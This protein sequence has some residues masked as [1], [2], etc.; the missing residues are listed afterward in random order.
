MNETLKLSINFINN[1][2]N[3]LYFN[4]INTNLY[5]YNS[6]EDTYNIKQ[7]DKLLRFKN[8]NNTKSNFKSL[9]NC[10]VIF[11]NDFNDNLN[12]YYNINNINN[13]FSKIL[14][15]YSSYSMNIPSFSLL[16]KSN[17]IFKYYKNI[18]LKLEAL[19]LGYKYKN[20]S[21]ISDI[22]SYKSNMYNANHSEKIIKSYLVN[23]SNKK[24]ESIMLYDNNKITSIFR[25]YSN[26]YLN[27]KYKLNNSIN[28]NL[29]LF[30]NLKTNIFEYDNYNNY[31]LT[32]QLSLNI[33]KI[34]NQNFKINNMSILSQSVIVKD[35][36]NDDNSLFISE[37]Q[38][39][40]INNN[41]EY[42]NK[43]NKLFKYKGNSKKIVK[44]II[45]KPINNIKNIKK[46]N[47][48]IT[49]TI[50]NKNIN[51]IKNSSKYKNSLKENNCNIN[52]EIKDGYYTQNKNINSKNN[53]A[54]NMCCIKSNTYKNTIKSSNKKIETNLENKKN[55]VCRNNKLN[56]INNNA[57]NTLNSNKSVLNNNIKCSKDSNANFSKTKL[58]SNFNSRNNN[59]P[60]IPTNKRSFFNNTFIRNN[61]NAFKN[62]TT[63][64]KNLNN[65]IK[66]S[67][68][69]NIYCLNFKTNFDN[70]N[71]TKL[72]NQKISNLNNIN[73][74]NNNNNNN[75][76]LNPT[77]YKAKE[78]FKLP[79]K[80]G[81][82]KLINN[83][84]LN[85]N[86]ICS[87]KEKIV[88]KNIHPVKNNSSKSKKITNFNS[89][90]KFTNKKN[91]NN[92]KFINNLNQNT[93][94]KKPTLVKT[95]TS[96]SNFK[97]F[98][99]I[100]S[101]NEPSTLSNSNEKS[102]KKNIKNE[103][104]NINNAFNNA[105]KQIFF[106]V[107]INN[108]KKYNSEFNNE[109]PHKFDN[110][111]T[112]NF[113]K[114]KTLYKK[115]NNC[116]TTSSKSIDITI[117]NKEL[118]NN[119]LNQ[120][121]AKSQNIDCLNLNIKTFLNDYC[122]LKLVRDK[123]NKYT[124]LENELNINKNIYKCLNSC[125]NN[126]N[127]ISNKDCICK[128]SKINKKSI[129]MHTFNYNKSDF[130]FKKSTNRNNIKNNTTK[131]LNII[132]SNIELIAAN[133]TKNFNNNNNNNNTNKEIRI[134]NIHKSCNSCFSLNNEPIPLDKQKKIPYLKKLVPM[135]F[136][137]NNL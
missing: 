66:N 30:N 7:I 75:L 134:E 45:P 111:N 107:K 113:H 54:K 36:I 82:N 29:Y 31:L 110:F 47:I 86:K 112:G 63:P 14:D 120:N 15:Y 71:D 32:K 92:N 65:N 70:E 68:K 2:N 135:S 37:S 64:P 56:T 40:N 133:D 85:N 53:I 125:T 59:N 108:N 114:T 127:N 128:R 12:S 131:D 21:T 25:L 5:Y 9:Y 126:L 102:L 52:K 119:D 48:T 60:N 91:N 87:L 42:S 4:I 116:N 129:S 49:T 27:S 124:G 88:N 105:N 34:N 95:N 117:I 106:R 61:K 28:F 74:D 8:N 137:K 123:S 17:P 115:N 98:N 58:A 99:K 50:N 109:N 23:T 73:N 118:S 43:E 18:K 93:E 67:K 6:D 136:K 130:I 103:I 122:E 20:D 19:E 69:E 62:N 89:Y 26:K 10:N 13:I 83:K 80:E 46:N 96:C 84:N 24:S 11:S 39:F 22:N 1:K 81:I 44:S 79:S 16:K 77:K 35:N 72:K 3:N 100:N 121:Y 76:F 51:S 57:L 33:L 97:V 90:K 104:N 94:V 132:T 101:N 41:I 78:A 38:I 55:N